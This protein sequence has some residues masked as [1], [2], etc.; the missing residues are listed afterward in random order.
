MGV[1]S[2]TWRRWRLSASR[3]TAIANA[4]GL[5]LGDD[6]WPSA[7]PYEALAAAHE[8]SRMRRNHFWSLHGMRDLHVPACLS[9]NACSRLGGFWAL[10]LGAPH[11]VCCS[12]LGPL[13]SAQPRS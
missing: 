2:S 3:D 7:A 11:V 8:H 1:G 10:P 13:S 4:S 9:R 6:C 12:S 5:R